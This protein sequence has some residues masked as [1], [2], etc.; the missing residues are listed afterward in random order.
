MQAV[1][2]L[3]RDLLD[4]AP[5][6]VDAGVGDEDVDRPERR[7]DGVDERVCGFG[8]R[9]VGAGRRRA[10]AER[11]HR[12]GHLL[13]GGGVRPVADGDVVAVFGQAERDGAA[14]PARGA[15]DERGGHPLTLGGV[16]CGPGRG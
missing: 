8:S 6:S 5:L 7:L 10:A 14:D 11:A 2:F 12:V 3:E 16:R 4:A 1:P 15:G 13:R 9:E